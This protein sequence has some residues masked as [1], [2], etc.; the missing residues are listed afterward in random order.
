[1][2]WTNSGSSTPQNSDNMA[3]DLHPFISQT[4]QMRQDMLDSA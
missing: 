1:M 4:I 2:F 3:A